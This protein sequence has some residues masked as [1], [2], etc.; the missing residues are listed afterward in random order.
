M[1]AEVAELPLPFL[2]GTCGGLAD[3]RTGDAG[4]DLFITACANME[5]FSSRLVSRMEDA[6]LTVLLGASDSLSNRLRMFLGAR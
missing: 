6:G 3:L 1:E 4:A 5:S 2:D